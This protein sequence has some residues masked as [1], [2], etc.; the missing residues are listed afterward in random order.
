MSIT[1]QLEKLGYPSREKI[2][3]SY[4]DALEPFLNVL[5]KNDIFVFSF[6][7]VL[8]SHGSITE[9]LG[10]F[11][12]IKLPILERENESLTP[13]QLSLLASLNDVP[14]TVINC[15]R[16]Y[17]RRNKILEKIHELS[18]E[19]V[20]NKRIDIN[21]YVPLLSDMTKS[22]CQWLKENFGIS[23]EFN[24]DG[25]QLSIKDYYTEI[26]N[27]NYERI[28]DLFS[29]LGCVYDPSIG[30]QNN[31]LKVYIA[32]ETQE[33]NFFGDVYLSLNPDVNAANVNPYWHYLTY[34]INEGRK[35]R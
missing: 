3:N 10:D 23:Y 34:G 24:Y 2:E 6:D 16:L 30:I 8:S 1:Q 27:N 13:F 21:F 7:E 9:H 4:R 18:E 29:K 35:V 28:V 25:S 12:S 19:T 17:S 14:F 32:L 15:E 20:I 33:Y 26:L 31:F 5:S 22:D 11:L